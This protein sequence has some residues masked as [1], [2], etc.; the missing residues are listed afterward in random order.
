MFADR[1]H[2]KQCRSLHWWFIH[3]ACN[4]GL[5]V[6]TAFGAPIKMHQP[7]CTSA[8]WPQT[9]PNT[10]NKPN[11]EH[12]TTGLQ[13]TCSVVVIPH[14]SLAKRSFVPQ[15]EAK[16]ASQQMQLTALNFEPRLLLLQYPFRF[17][18]SRSCSLLPTAL[19]LPLM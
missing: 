15:T 13:V 9:S 6:Q 16:S 7:L 4:R 8:M 10:Q 19:L 1:I 2:H 5:S 11:V 18:C 3:L 12:G 17:C 14:G